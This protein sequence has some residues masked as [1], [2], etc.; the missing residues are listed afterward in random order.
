ATRCSA[1]CRRR[2]TCCRPRSRPKSR[3][4][5]RRASAATSPRRTASGTS[6]RRRGSCSRT[7]RPERGGSGSKISEMLGFA[8]L[9]ILLAQPP[10]GL[11]ASRQ[12]AAADAVAK[13][14]IALGIDPKPDDVGGDH[15]RAADAEAYERAGAPAWLSQQIEEESD[16]IGEPPE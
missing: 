13:Y 6:S 16:R 1:S 11:K 4:V 14:G 9:W 10:T 3:R 7:A 5:S 2:T 8:G 12:N 15:P